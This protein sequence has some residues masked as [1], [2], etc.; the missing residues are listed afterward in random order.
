MT[1]PM[2]RPSAGSLRAAKQRGGVEPGDRIID[3]TARRA[4]QDDPHE[5][6]IEPQSRAQTL[7][8]GRNVLT[9]QGI[10]E[11]SL[12]LRVMLVAAL[13]LVTAGAI[14]V[15]TRS[16]E[17]IGT[18]ITVV[19]IPTSRAPRPRPS[20]LTDAF[21]GTASRPQIGRL[22]SQTSGDWRGSPLSVAPLTSP[23][24]WLG[25]TARRPTLSS[26]PSRL[27]ASTAPPG[28]ARSRST[29]NDPDG[30]EPIVDG[31]WVL[32]LRPGRRGDFGHYGHLERSDRDYRNWRRWPRAEHQPS[33]ALRPRWSPLLP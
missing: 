31:W 5:P 17:A 24:S 32:H 19:P 28:R 2:R 18:G 29:A 4:T 6:R 12:G 13:L 26:S 10:L 16:A 11:R 3:R 7:I 33:S 30:Q 25:T 21:R 20:A 8:K 23:L 1:A 27:A 14:F 9:Q 22:S 15:A